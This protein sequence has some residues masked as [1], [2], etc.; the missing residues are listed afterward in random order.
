MPNSG[1]QGDENQQE[2]VKKR[3]KFYAFIYNLEQKPA[4]VINLPILKENFKVSFNTF[5]TVKEIQAIFDNA[6]K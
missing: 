2:L 6:I 5:P 1:P 4:P 3:Q